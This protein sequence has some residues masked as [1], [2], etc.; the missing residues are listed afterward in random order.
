MDIIVFVDI[1]TIIIIGSST[2]RS[3]S[4]DSARRRENTI[5]E[6]YATPTNLLSF[7]ASS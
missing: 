5:S 3:A 4:N 7:W 2:S 1:T 6:V